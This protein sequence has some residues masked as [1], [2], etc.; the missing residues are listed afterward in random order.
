MACSSTMCDVMERGNE[1]L[2]FVPGTEAC[3]E[4]EVRYII[5]DPLFR[6]LSK[7]YGYKVSELIVSLINFFVF[8]AHLERKVSKDFDPSNVLNQVILVL[9]QRSTNFNLFLYYRHLYAGPHAQELRT[10]D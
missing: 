2:D 4:S 1:I 7:L 10:A 5:V 9:P 6:G 3:S 8:K